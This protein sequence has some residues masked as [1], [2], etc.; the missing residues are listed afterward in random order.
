MSDQPIHV[1]NVP[2][3]ENLSI[4]IGINT[5]ASQNVQ[6]VISF[7][8]Q[9]IWSSGSGLVGNIYLEA[10]NDNQNFTQIPQTILAISGASGSHMI[11]IEKH[12]YGYVRLATDLSAGS[13]TANSRM[14]SKRK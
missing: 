5:S 9:F 2:L 7:S 8:V 6:E 4:G 3:F 10:S 1:A 12:S 11:N 13:A 14:N